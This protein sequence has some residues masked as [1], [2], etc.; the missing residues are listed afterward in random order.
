MNKFMAV[1][2]EKLTL[3]VGSAAILVIVAGTGGRSSA[4][5]SSGSAAD[6]RDEFRPFQGQQ[7]APNLYKCPAID[8]RCA[9]R[10]SHNPKSSVFDSARRAVCS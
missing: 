3:V 1:K 5:G 7:Q 6:S 9:P 8:K 4:S 10:S 2:R